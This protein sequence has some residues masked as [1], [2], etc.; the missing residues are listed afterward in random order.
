MGN[1]LKKTPTKS[2]TDRQ[3]MCDKDLL[4]FFADHQ[5]YSVIEIAAHFHVTQTAIRGRLTRLM[6]A[7]LVTRKVEVTRERGRPKHTYFL[8]SRAVDQGTV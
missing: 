7:E 8:T 6:A 4:S 1:E 2:P 3:P 5:G